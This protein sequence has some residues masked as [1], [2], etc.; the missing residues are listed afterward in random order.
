[1]IKKYRKN[2][3]S[4]ILIKLNRFYEF[5][6]IACSSSMYNSRWSRIVLSS[7]HVHFDFLLIKVIQTNV[8]GTILRYGHCSLRGV[9]YEPWPI[10][11]GLETVLRAP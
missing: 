2:F 1:M 10:D 7:Y 4:S 9:A 8:P 5:Q 11:G 6:I 3:E